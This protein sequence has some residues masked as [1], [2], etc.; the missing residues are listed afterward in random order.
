[1]PEPET[2]ATIIKLWLTFGFYVS[3]AGLVVRMI[4]TLSDRRLVTDAG[5]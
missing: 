5:E 3:L 4:L 1:M 2:P